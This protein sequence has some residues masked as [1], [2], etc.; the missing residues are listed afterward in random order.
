MSI[1]YKIFIVPASTSSPNMAPYSSRE[2]GTKTF[3]V[4]QNEKPNYLTSNFFN[5][6]FQRG[7]PAVAIPENIASKYVKVPFAGFVQ[8]A[9]DA[10]LY[11]VK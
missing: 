4:H 10:P 11:A 8:R 9:V 3:P 7:S 1:F 2:P 5:Q 6:G